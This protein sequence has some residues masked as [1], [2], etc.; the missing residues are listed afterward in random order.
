MKITHMG[1]DVTGDYE[2]Y[3]IDE[4]MSWLRGRSLEID[5]EVK[6]A[7]CEM[8]TGIRKTPIMQQR[9]D[10]FQT[11]QDAIPDLQHDLT[12]HVYNEHD[13]LE[14]YQASCVKCRLMSVIGGGGILRKPVEPPKEPC[15]RGEDGWCKTCT[16][17]HNADSS[18]A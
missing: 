13:Q 1:Q 2:Q 9:D 3:L 18:F 6:R 5:H 4:V 16:P 15:V 12:G 14:E 11:V 10:L 17:S 8:L 7:I